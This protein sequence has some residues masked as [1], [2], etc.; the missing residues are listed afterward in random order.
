MSNADFQDTWERAADAEHNAC[1]AR[2]IGDLVDDARAGRYGEYHQL[3]RAIAAR[4]T[5][6]QAGP[7]LM[8]VLRRDVDYLVRYHAGAALIHLLATRKFKPAQL[9]ANWPSRPADLDAVE[10]MLKER[11]SSQ[12]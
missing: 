5:L 1:L 7:V 9:S 4:A 6:P 3:W 2:P 10:R 12:L 8:E 11:L